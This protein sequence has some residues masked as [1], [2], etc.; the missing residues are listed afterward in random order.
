M[1]N[2]AKNPVRMLPHVGN[3]R[4]L[5]A[6]AEILHQLRFKFPLDDEASP[7]HDMEACRSFVQGKFCRTAESKP[8]GDKEVMKVI[9]KKQVE[10]GTRCT[11]CENVFTKRQIYV[12][13][14]GDASTCVNKVCIEGGWA[15][16]EL[17]RENRNEK[18]RGAKKNN[19][20]RTWA[21]ET[22]LTDIAGEPVLVPKLVNDMVLSLDKLRRRAHKED[23]S[24]AKMRR[25]GEL[26]VE[27][28]D[29]SWP[30]VPEAPKED[31]SDTLSMDTTVSAA[32][33]LP[34]PASSS[35]TTPRSTPSSSRGTSTNSD[36]KSK[37]M[38]DYFAP[39]LAPSDIL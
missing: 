26:I 14:N 5:E 37:S 8:L 23:V 7:T 12:K 4:Q 35:S 28:V 30:D 33:T 13:I 11:A 20:R 16:G 17:H 27:Y 25:W 29:K 15:A 36:E 38:R 24:K 31:D 10:Q 19:Y 34:S 39:V 22:C 18:K 2:V 3:L 21:I 6:T 32:W 1:P 9:T